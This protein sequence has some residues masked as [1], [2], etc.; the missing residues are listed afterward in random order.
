MNPQN[1][2]L[3]LV[4]L[5]PALY[6]ILPHLSDPVIIITV[7]ISI[8]SFVI[9]ALLIPQTKDLNIKANLFGR[10]LN[11]G[12]QGKKMQVPESMGI[13]PGTTW[14]VTVCLLQVLV[15]S[16]SPSN[17]KTMEWN[18][19]LFS[20]CFMLFL[21]FADDVLE[22]RWRYKL[23]LPCLAALPLL[24]AYHGLTTIVVPKPFRSII[25][26]IPFLD[27]LSV[28][29]NSDVIASGVITILELGI[30]Y[31]VYMLLMAIFCSNTINI[32]AG[33]NGL[34]AG[35]TFV[36]A[37]A[38]LV[39]NLIELDGE[40]RDSHLFSLI[41]IVPF[42][43]TTLGLLCHNWYPS[44]VFVGD[45]FT[46]FAGMTLAVV[47]VLGHFSKTLML[48]FIPQW[49]NFFIS[50]P[51]LLFLHCPRHRIPKYNEKTKLLESSKN[52]TLLN[53]VLEIT[54]P[55]SEENLCKVMMAIQIV[56]CAFGF[57]VR[58]HL[59]KLFY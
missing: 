39:H 53:A 47:G 3:A 9:T 56:S 18:A 24:T 25:G 22:L 1:A 5:A 31:R 57:Y 44:Q 10:D 7:A 58:Y 43:A 34:E 33:I 32:L 11:K 48:F 50:V 54:G 52:F 46:Y 20:S 42:I 21:G 30:L 23:I 35:Q 45:T 29:D 51:Q 37:C 55:M 16:I 13:V 27:W 15:L 28:T 12:E 2:I 36:I 40:F 14:V 41:Y 38:V 49:L 19:G 8:L 6:L 26:S 17:A 59:S 4:P